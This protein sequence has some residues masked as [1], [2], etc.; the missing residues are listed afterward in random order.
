ML[1]KLA[2]KITDYY[3]SKNKI[4][5]DSREMFN[6]CF[7]ILLSTI[8]NGISILF[9]GLSTALYAETFIF[10]FTFVLFRG[11][12]DGSHAKTHFRCF[13]SLIIVFSGFVLLQLLVEYYILYYLSI[14]I[15]MAIASLII[16][17]ALCP[18]DN[19]NKPIDRLE[20]TK[21]RKKM[22]VAVIFIICAIIPLYC[23]QSLANYA[24]VISYPLFSVTFSMIIGII[25]NKLHKKNTITIKDNCKNIPK[26][27]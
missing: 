25:T 17:I 9:I 13:L 1:S 23:F 24:F 21:L 19:V 11:I 18:I 22:Y 8:V 14:S 5:A 27:T 10:N 3:I 15:S 4:N 2:V 26:S 7:E 16:V 6:Y 20:R 12:C